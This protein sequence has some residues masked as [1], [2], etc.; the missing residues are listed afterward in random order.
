MLVTHGLTHLP[1]CDVIITM[2]NGKITEIGTYSEL[3]DKNVAFSE[4]VRTYTS[5]EDSNKGATTGDQ[6][7]VLSDWIPLCLFLLILNW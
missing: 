6:L 5:M 1:Q 7:N 2:E 3:I 4:F